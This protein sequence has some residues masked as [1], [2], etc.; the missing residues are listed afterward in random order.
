MLEIKRS[1]IRPQTKTRCVCKLQVIQ[2]KAG[3]NI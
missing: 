1:V 2:R 3:L